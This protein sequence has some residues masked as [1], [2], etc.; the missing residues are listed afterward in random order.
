MVG[1]AAGDDHEIGLAAL[2]RRGE[3][4]RAG[5]FVASVARMMK[6]RAS[7]VSG[8][9]TRPLLSRVLATSPEVTRKS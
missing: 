6:Q 2:G 7:G 8:T 5:E 4:E 9:G 3:A 1:P